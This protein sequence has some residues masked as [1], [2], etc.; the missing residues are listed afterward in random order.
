MA[1]PAVEF[2]TPFLHYDARR[3][4]VTTT[5][6]HS[7]RSGKFALRRMAFAM[8]PAGLASAFVLGVYADT[9]ALLFELVRPLVVSIGLAISLQAVLSLLLRGLTAGTYAAIVILA[10]TVISKRL[11]LVAIAVMLV[12]LYARRRGWRLELQAPLAAVVLL[13]LIVSVARVLTSGAFDPADLVARPNG[14][15]AAEP[16]SPDI[17]LIMLDGY[18][19][20]DTL[21]SFGYDNTWFEDE[22]VERGFGVSSASTT[23]YPFTGPTVTTMLNMEHLPDIER[24]NPAPKTHVGQTRALVEATNN[25]PVLAE[26]EHRGYWTVSAGLTEVRGSI[27]NVDEYIDRGEIRLWE[28]QVLQRTTI[29]PELCEAVVIPQHRSL[30]ESTFTAIENAGAERRD[31]PIFMFGHVMSPHTPIVF[32]AEG[33][34]VTVRGSGDCATQFGIDATLIGLEQEVFEH[35]MAE[36]VHYLNTRTLDALDSIIENNPAAVVIVFSDHGARHSEEVTEEWFRNFFAA[37]TPGRD[38][39][40]GD[41]ARPID[42]FPRLFGEY[43]GLAIPTPDD[44]AYTSTHGISMPLDLTVWRSGSTR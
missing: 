17:F 3:M 42:I 33:A 21:A 31:D 18:P 43:F 32:N 14:T 4:P 38:G 25:G 35:A 27:R 15:G 8:A 7:E 26:L 5:H 1:G 37:R 30:I 16:S 23:S 22:L 13:M 19:R 36:Q 41:D 9:G 10:M 2:L 24:L 44:R 28:R 20:S 34:P 12:A 29:W 39:V 6:I 40:F 11:L